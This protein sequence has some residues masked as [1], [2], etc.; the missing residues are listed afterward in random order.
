M[1]IKFITGVMSQTS[2][3]IYQHMYYVYKQHIAKSTPQHSLS[4]LNTVTHST[5]RLTPSK[6]HTT[7]N[8]Y[9]PAVKTPPH[10]IALWSIQTHKVYANACS[11]AKFKELGNNMFKVNQLY[12]VPTALPIPLEQANMRT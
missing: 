10:T 9:V 8:P 7:E 2:I 12:S 3:Y 1:L 5:P 6:I 11:Y 4:L